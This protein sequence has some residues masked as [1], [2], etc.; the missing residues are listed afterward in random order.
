MEINIHNSLFPIVILLINSSWYT[1]KRT[2]SLYQERRIVSTYTKT[3]GY[4]E[5]V[6]LDVI[7]FEN[8]NIIFIEEGK[9]F[10]LQSAIMQCKLALRNMAD[11]NHDGGV[12]Y[13]FI[14]TGNK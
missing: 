4:Q 12:L 3:A 14:M 8:S 13:F 6:S 2:L 9:Q 7:S 5:F 10:K 1:T 11:N